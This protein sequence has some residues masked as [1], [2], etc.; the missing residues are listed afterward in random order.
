MKNDNSQYCIYHMMQFI[1][2]EFPGSIVLQ[3]IHDH[4]GK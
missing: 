2:P 3:S 1:I 4:L